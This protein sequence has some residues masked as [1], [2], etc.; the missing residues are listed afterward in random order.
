ML[1]RDVRLPQRVP[2]SGCRLVPTLFVV[3]DSDR[4]ACRHSL[5]FLSGRRDLCSS[6]WTT[7]RMKLH[8]RRVKKPP[9]VCSSASST[10]SSEG[11]KRRKKKNGT[12]SPTKNASSCSSPRSKYDPEDIREPVLS[13]D[14]Q[15]PN[16]EVAIQ[17]ENIFTE[18]APW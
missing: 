14:S 16:L 18:L 9:S 2:L 8:P 11:V 15:L 7:R 4:P 17:N 1:K 6:P 12:S 3:S 5:V 10:T 13:L